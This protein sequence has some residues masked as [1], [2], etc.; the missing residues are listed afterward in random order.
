MAREEKTYLTIDLAELEEAILVLSRYSMFLTNEYNKAR[1]RY[2]YFNMLYNDRLAKVFVAHK[3]EGRSKEERALVACQKD[4]ELNGL[5]EKVEE[6]QMK[7]ERIEGLPVS[8]NM[9]ASIL[10]DILKRRV[11]ERR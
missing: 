1:S 11:G 9:H 2:K 6:Y 10:R 4:Q 5:R 7:A 3:I 8:I